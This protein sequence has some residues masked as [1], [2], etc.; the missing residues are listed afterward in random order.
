MSRHTFALMPLLLGMLASCATAIPEEEATPTCRSERECAA[1]WNA[2]EMWIRHR[3]GRTIEQKTDD[4]METGGR[5]VGNVLSV[6]VRKIPVD[7]GSWRIEAEMFCGKG[8]GCDPSPWEARKA[9]NRAV[10]VSWVEP[11]RN[12]AETE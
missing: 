2:A 1:K 8:V 9:F 4:Y 12:H 11:S 10:N 6:R 3:A 7:D 5:T